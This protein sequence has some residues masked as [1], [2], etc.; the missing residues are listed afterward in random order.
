[1]NRVP[2][3]VCYAAI[4]V[5]VLFLGVNRLPAQTPTPTPQA[6][7]PP[8]S[9]TPAAQDAEEEDRNPFAPEPAVALP[10]G[11]TGSDVNDPRAKLKPGLYN[12]GEA[13]M[14]M[15][16]LTLVKKP[17]AFQLGTNNPDDPKVQK[18]L[19][20]LNIPNAAKIPKTSTAHTS[21]SAASHCFFIV[22]SL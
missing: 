16:H 14:G 21:G 4:A 19:G 2:R 18:M 3:V 7:T 6:Q 13:A 22:P 8:P 11:M 1:M 15:K 20:Q 10:P 12:A 9:P 17:A 5:L